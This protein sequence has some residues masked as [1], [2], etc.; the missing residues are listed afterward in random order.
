MAIPATEVSSQTN[1]GAHID[2]KSFDEQSE[3]KDQP[4][5]RPISGNIFDRSVMI[6]S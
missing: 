2:H 6:S 4:I 1:L 5:I 3:Q